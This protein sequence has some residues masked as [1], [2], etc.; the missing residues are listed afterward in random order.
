MPAK[1]GLKRLICCVLPILFL[2]PVGPLHTQGQT[3]PCGC[4]LCPVALEDAAQEQLVFSVQGAVQPV[5]GVGGQGLCGV[6][7]HLTHTYVSDLLVRLTSPSGV[8]ITLMGPTGFSD[9]T[10]GTVWN[11]TMVP[12]GEAPAPDNNFNPVWS[13]TQP[14]GI[15]GQYDG[16][17]H[18]Y[19]GCLEDFHGGSV[20]GNWILEISD[21]MH[22]DDGVLL[23]VQLIF[24]DTQGL[25]CFPCRASAGNLIQ[26]DLR[27]C[28]GSPLLRMLP[29]P[30]YS[31]PL[32]PPPPTEYTY[33]Y[34]IGGSGSIL[35]E[36]LDTVDLRAYPPGTY[37]VCGL[38]VPTV[39]AAR[40][41]P[42]DGQYTL[43]ELGIDLSSGAAGVCGSLTTNCIDIVIEPALPDSVLEV[44]LCIDSCFTFLGRTYCQEGAYT[45]T[46]S[47]GNCLRVARLQLKTDRPEAVIHPPPP[48]SCGD[49]DLPLI[50]VPS[51]P[52]AQYLWS[53][54]S[55]GGLISAV[56]SDTALVRFPGLYQLTVCLESGTA[57]CCDTTT[58]TI[59]QDTLLLPMPEW[60]AADTLVCAG[61]TAS[62]HLTTPL[63]DGATVAW[64]VQGGTITGGQGT[65]SLQVIW[66]THPDTA[67]ITIRL[68]NGCG[69]HQETAR[70]VP[71]RRPPSSGSILGDSTFCLDATGSW[72]YLPAPDADDWM[73]TLPPMAAQHAPPNAT[74]CS[75]D[76]ISDG[77]GLLCVTASNT[78]GASAPT[79]LSLQVYPQPEI[80]TLFA[81]CADDT[82]GYV[83]FLSVAGGHP[84]Y[85]SLIHPGTF[86]GGAFES[87]LMPNNAT[88]VFQVQD[89]NGCSADP[90]ATPGLDCSCQIS[91][92]AMPSDTA[93]FCGADTARVAPAV[94]VQIGPFDTLIYLLHEQ[95]GPIPGAI[96]ASNALPE[97]PRFPGMAPEVTY[98]ITA[99][100]MPNTGAQADV[101]KR[102]SN[103]TPV[104]WRD[105]PIA[106]WEG[107]PEACA[108]DTVVWLIRGSGHF[109]VWAWYEDPNG[110]KDAI[111]LAD[112]LPAALRI[113]ATASGTWLLHSAA[114]QWCTN[115]DAISEKY[116]EVL[117]TPEV[118]RLTLDTAR[119]FGVAN[120]YIRIDSIA[121]GTPPVRF[122]L[123]GGAYGPDM[124]FPNLPSGT[125]LLE[126]EDASGCVGSVSI[127][128][129]DPIDKKIALGPDREAA[130]GDLLYLTLMSDPP[131]LQWNT[132][133]WTPPAGRADGTKGLEWEA[134]R[135]TRFTATALDTFGCAFSD[136]V[137]IQVQQD[138]EVY[139]PNAITPDAATNNI[140]Q[141]YAGTSVSVINAVQV[142]DRWGTLVYE[143]LNTLP[144]DAGSGWD[145]R[146][147]GRTV[148]AGV[149]AYRVE[150]LMT[151]GK[152]VI[153]FGNLSVIR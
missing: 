143:R 42:P 28:A 50:A 126:M 138:S 112:S 139:I 124:A 87:A 39:Q 103:S 55:P 149:Y 47:E 59:T 45:D 22:D 110:M 120:A 134:D 15:L 66:D 60:Y 121:G 76:W 146:M 9:P 31:P 4:A 24:C 122:R 69:I 17:Y 67:I 12:C 71:L 128:F 33:T 152:P 85:T 93:H 137:L 2:L 63:P 34:A 10:D 61:D 25:E 92:G 151:T 96:I 19:A 37:T 43:Q 89:A 20:D 131:G 102:F 127:H 73:W 109:P 135:T 48:W 105:L 5:L 18:P 114:D 140:W 104:V 70:F 83:V 36:Y 153:I 90:V 148:D 80:D 8:S 65:D 57:L 108:G 38:S 30:A 52:G 95:S 40:L 98:F 6:S 7:L 99:L 1:N 77:Q 119:C 68:E 107:P 91:A 129:P 51:T 123:N 133:L 94:G 53:A 84:P 150:L 97:F 29:L 75:T 125:H 132:V 116:L 72:A 27:S 74:A 23:D 3:A 106:Y 32:Q 81:F 111:L 113:P 101:C 78:C 117:S 35:L 130:F 54:L 46:L 58:V 56:V 14:W 142:F 26:P 145:G 16:R 11:I 44:R 147:R 136:S 49:G 141:V 100:A 144:G 41:P 13:N 86:Q 62:Y 79:C 82:S 118:V 64:H 21:M 115:R 88:T